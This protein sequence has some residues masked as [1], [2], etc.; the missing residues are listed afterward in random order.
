MHKNYT[1]I[2]DINKS[3]PN[4]VGKG[5]DKILVQF[6]KDYAIYLQASLEPNF[7]LL[8][9]ELLARFKRV[10]F[11]GRIGPST[12]MY[13]VIMPNHV[14]AC[15]DRYDNTLTFIDLKEGVEYFVT[16]KYIETLSHRT[17]NLVK[18]LEH[19]RIY[20][21]SDTTFAKD[22]IEYYKLDNLYNT[23]LM[24]I[25]SSSY[26]DGFSTVS[27]SEKQASDG[28]FMDGIDMEEQEF[29]EI[30]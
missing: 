18:W 11:D 27:S 15:I 28:L 9:T 17:I 13:K 4:K 6:K 29:T 12:E 10:T 21:I 5:F 23:K 19:S 30:S 26:F 8:E 16:G 24:K 3:F 22:V 7:L 14:V 1:P 25:Y 2:F 20:V